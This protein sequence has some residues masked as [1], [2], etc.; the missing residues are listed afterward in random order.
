LGGIFLP[1]TSLFSSL[2][3]LH[4]KS[5]LPIQSLASRTPNHHLDVGARHSRTAVV[6]ASSDVGVSRPS[7]H[8]SGHFPLSV[9]LSLLLSKPKQHQHRALDPTWLLP[10]IRRTAVSLTSCF[11]PQMGYTFSISACFGWRCCIRCTYCG[12][13]SDKSFSVHPSVGRRLVVG[14]A[15]IPCTPHYAE[16]REQLGCHRSSLEGPGQRFRRR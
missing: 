13:V 6:R 2:T 14:Q 16:P 8:L 3:C 5:G 15:P 12:T 1:F 10:M 9:N 11:P 4:L 7:K